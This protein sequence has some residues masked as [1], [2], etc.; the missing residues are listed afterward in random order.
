M[1]G[2]VLAM[3]ELSRASR[4]YLWT[5]QTPLNIRKALEM[6]PLYARYV[7]P[8]ATKIDLPLSPASLPPR[9]P[10]V[11]NAPESTPEK[12]KKRKRTIE[13]PYPAL[14]SGDGITSKLEG[15]S[16]QPSSTKKERTKKRKRETKPVEP[17]TEGDN[18][19][20]SQKHKAVLTKFARSTKVAEVVR[21]RTEDKV[22]MAE[23]NITGTEELHGNCSFRYHRLNSCADTFRSRPSPSTPARSR[24]SL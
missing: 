6:A 5:P 9:V 4:F 12:G 22:T 16:V 23:Q 19:P 7:P 11:E 14:D 15:Q 1:L 24:N 13:Q 17:G 3:L 20:V 8:K 18:G 2:V 21:E 10:S